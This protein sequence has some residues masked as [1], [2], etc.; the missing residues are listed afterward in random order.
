MS[1]YLLIILV[2]LLLFAGC[3]FR[4]AT[5]RLGSEGSG[6]QEYRYFKYE[7][8]YIIY[9]L[10]YKEHKDYLKA[11]TLFKELYDKTSNPE[12]LQEAAKLLIALKKYDEALEELKTL[13]Q[14]DPENV[15]L[16]RL[17]TIA[18]IKLGKKDEALKSADKALELDPD[19]L[20][21]VDMTASIYMMEREYKKA[22]EAYEH[23]YEK[24]HDDESLIRMASI[25]FHKMNDRKKSMKLLESHRKIIGCSEK[26]CLFLAEIYRQENDLDGL[27]S[28][29]SN[30]YEATGKSEYAQKAAEIYT[31]EKRYKKAIEIL[32]ASDADERLLLAVLKQSREYKKALALAKKL[33]EETLDPI[34]QAEYGVLLYEAAEKKDDPSLLK[35]V[36]KALESAFEEGVDDSLYLNYLGYLLIDHDLDIKRGM[37]LVEKALEKAPDSPFYLDSLAWG[38]YKLGKCADAKKY[39]KRVVEKMGLDDEEIKL[40]WEKINRCRSE[41]K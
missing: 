32:E 34:W 4:S 41:K 24:H 13:L 27:A 21:N 14:N 3:S 6:K 31:Y 25:L 16:Y 20:Q 17:M 40:H 10:Y 29:Y 36:Q 26:V 22:Y 12:Y 11:Y 23:Y 8:E 1:R 30:L 35:N 9:A 33:Y 39:M 2:S 15:E 37:K 7:N 38:Y 19:N 5:D 28:V 18:Y